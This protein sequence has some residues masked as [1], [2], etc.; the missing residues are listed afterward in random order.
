MGEEGYWLVL[1]CWPVLGIFAGCLSYWM[2]LNK[3]G[4]MR[5]RSKERYVFDYGLRLLLRLSV[6]ATELRVGTCV[7]LE[8]CGSDCGSRSLLRCTRCIHGQDC[9]E[10]CRIT[11]TA[12]DCCLSFE[13]DQ[14]TLQ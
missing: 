3:G 4:E 2:G 11:A 6:L 10:L 7:M 1:C 13:G 12:R 9:S 14:M 5:Q 8:D